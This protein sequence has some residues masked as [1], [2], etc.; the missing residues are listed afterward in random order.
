MFRTSQLIAASI[1]F[2]LLAP[3]AHGVE[4]EVKC[5]SG[6]LK[7]VGQYAGC[8][9]K[10]HAVAVS[11]NL[12]PDFSKCDEK[13]TPKYTKLETTAGSGVCPTE[14]DET[15]VRSRVSSDVDEVAVILSGGA[16]PGCG[17][18]AVG[19]SE[20]CDG[21]DLDGQ[22]C[23]SFGFVGGTLTCTANCALD[24]SAC[25]TPS[26]GN[27]TLDGGEEC[28]WGNLGG[29]TC[30]SLGYSAT[31]ELGC[32]P[33]QC[34]FDVGECRRKIVFVTS[35][36]HTGSLGGLAGADNICQARAVAAGLAG[37][38]RAWL[39]S[40]VTDASARLSESQFGYELVD[41]T[42]IADDWADLLDGSLDNPI[43]LDENGLPVTANPWTGT[44]ATGTKFPD[45]CTGFTST[46]NSGATGSSTQTTSSWSLASATACSTS[47]PL[48]CFEL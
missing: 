32:V 18:G 11:K 29:E 25:A 43:D 27:G 38:F 2:A 8:R 12:P 19:G 40:G 3:A 10:A 13:F 14:S 42:K 45:T 44:Y 22:S 46:S 20:S 39:S 4:P 16:L 15:S 41:G 48:Y 31:G 21:A 5:E 17:D 6:K 28:D 7:V 37:T 30:L 47:H 24:L 26:C 33:T 36:I 34:T 1:G 35:T 9:L 23:T